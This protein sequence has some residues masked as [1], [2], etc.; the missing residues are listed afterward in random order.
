MSLSG[1]DPD[2]GSKGGMVDD[3][4]EVRDFESSP[5][6]DLDVPDVSRQWIPDS[7]LGFLSKVRSGTVKGSKTL[8][9]KAK[10]KNYR[11]IT[12]A[13]MDLVHRAKGQIQGM[14]ETGGKSKNAD[15]LH[16]D[17]PSLDLVSSTLL[18]GLQGIDQ[19]PGMLDEASDTADELAEQEPVEAEDQLSTEDGSDMD[20]SGDSNDVE[21]EVGAR[22]E[23]G[24][25]PVP[26]LPAELLERIEELEA[27]IAA[28]NK[29]AQPVPTSPAELLER[30][31]GQENPTGELESTVARLQQINAAV[32][33]RLNQIGGQVAVI[34]RSLQAT[35][36]FA[37]HENFTCG[38]CSAHGMVATELLCTSCWME[39][40]WGWSPPQVGEPETGSTAEVG[41]GCPPLEPSHP[42]ATL[43]RILISS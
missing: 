19:E 39:Q 4:S 35:V 34:D 23:E 24:T 21:Y 31:V 8:K 30:I 27:V 43:E 9:E 33:E 42:T 38:A 40:L 41:S 13:V 29:E 20:E 12:K 3:P 6:R 25:Q 7:I 17:V 2:R 10:S 14:I 18:E 36:G 15:L 5:L 37:A 16:L 32:V 11:P 26:T 22:V 1:S 28:A